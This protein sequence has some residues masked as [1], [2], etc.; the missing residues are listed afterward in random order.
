MSVSVLVVSC[1]LLV[2]L[3]RVL[4]LGGGGGKKETEGFSDAM[5]SYLCH[6]ANA[7]T[8]MD[9]VLDQWF[10]GPGCLVCQNGIL[11]QSAWHSSA[12]D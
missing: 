10:D 7:G 9:H 4:A 12:K 1:R 2:V 6:P 8:D 3:V 11:I 5:P